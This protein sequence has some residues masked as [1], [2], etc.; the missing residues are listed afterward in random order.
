MAALLAAVLGLPACAA[1]PELGGDGGGGGGGDDDDGPGPGGPDAGSASGG[2]GC[3]GGGGAAQPFGHHARPYAAGTILPSHRS[4]AELDDAVRL[5]YSAWKSRHVEAS[6]RPGRVFV[7]HGS[8]GATVSEG[9]G[10]GMIIAVFMA[11]YDPE[12]REV[13]DGMWRFVKDH[14]SAGAG[15]LMAWK[16]DDGCAPGHQPRHSAAD[17]D[18]DI[19]Y[20]LLLADKQWGSDGAIDYRGEAVKLLAA[21]RW[22]EV[23]AGHRFV[24]LGDWTNPGDAVHFDATRTSDFMPG[25]FAAFEAAVGGGVWRGVSDHSF[26]MVESLQAQHAPVTGLVPD[27]VVRPASNPAP[28]PAHFL[29]NATDGAYSFNACRFPL[30]LGVHVLLTG[31]AR[32]RAI[33]ARQNAWL[34]GATGDDPSRIKA[35]YWLDGNVVG[36]GNFRNDAFLGP[37]GVGAMVDAANQGWVNGIWDLLTSSGAGGY[38]DETLKVL[39]MIAMSGNWWSP[40]TAPCPR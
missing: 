28:A 11:G 16:V 37:F 26:Q 4:Q 24:R 20:A 6:C 1:T 19:A 34:R 8:G 38:Y 15:E 39:S 21:I 29:E 33:L 14:P 3:A 30:R 2:D 36:S 23:D 9:A 13:F 10:Y 18:L 40:D 27:F 25:H 32:A 5:A 7:E 31:D 12:A 35:G 17:A 22:A